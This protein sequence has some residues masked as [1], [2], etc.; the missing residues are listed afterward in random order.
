[1]LLSRKFLSL[2]GVSVLALN[3]ISCASVAPHARLLTAERPKDEAFRS[4]LK[5]ELST[6]NVSIGASASELGDTLNRV[7]GKELYNGSTKTLGLTARVLRNGP[8]VV[9]AADNFLQLTVPISLSLSYGMFETPTVTTKLKFKLSAKVTPDWKFNI[10]AYYLGLSDALAEELKLGPISIKPRGMM[11]AITQPV[12]RNLSELIGRKLNEKF[13]LR[14]E[15]TKVW[16]AA[17]KPI[18]LDKNYHAWLQVTPHELLLYPLYA[19][20]NQL[21]VS[22]GVKSYAEVVVG[23]EPPARAPRP[24][25]NLT[26]ATGT[27]K[28]F[29]VA[30]NT[31]LFYRDI[32]DIA[33]PLLLNKEF[34]SD[35]KSVVLKQLDLYGN[36]DRLMVKVETTG[37]LDGVFYLTC[38]PV[39]NSQTNQFS[40]EDLDFELQSK[41]L[42]LQS[43]DWFLHGTIRDS[44]REKLN[45]DL[46]QRLTQARELASKSMAHV[47]IGDNLY[48][49]GTVKTVKVNDVMVQRDKISIQVYTEGETAIVL[50]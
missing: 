49:T 36:G 30:L 3:L 24:L 47:S 21:Q 9:G 32:L 27:D 13:S 25:P 5:K 33:A 44:I 12:Q 26:L 37:S 38:R 23:P 22:V 29:R 17:Y 7:V 50:H 20:N 10:Q 1:L 45:L 40:V 31:D 41:S 28:S 43:A 42:L 4:E 19:G 18:L 8:I 11:E 48:L 6:F 39:F 14:A 34:N 46:T 15:V 2:L 16:N 35:G